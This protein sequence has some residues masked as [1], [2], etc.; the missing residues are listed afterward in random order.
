MARHL[1]TYFSSG[2]DPMA[3]RL[4]ISSFNLSHKS[5]AIDTIH[6]F[7]ASS[8]VLFC[9]AKVNQHKMEIEQEKGR[10]HGDGAEKQQ[11]CRTM[12]HELKI[13]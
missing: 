2:R 13:G 11:C 7:N 1:V 3:K 9:V 5:A 6:N 10:A 12:G 4:A 8:N